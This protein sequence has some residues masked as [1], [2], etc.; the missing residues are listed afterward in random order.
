MCCSVWTFAVVVSEYIAILSFV[1][2]K[3]F[4][5]LQ[6]WL[7]LFLCAADSDTDSV[8]IIWRFFHTQAL[9]I[10]IWN[11]TM[12]TIKQN[13]SC[14][15]AWWESPIKTPPRLPACT[16]A[17]I[18]YAAQLSCYFHEFLLFAFI[19]RCSVFLFVWILVFHH[20][21]DSMGLFILMINRV[22][23]H[24]VVVIKY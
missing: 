11:S 24:F 10:R 7:L 4:A 22:I 2:F 20:Y 21:W 15:S 17:S 8:V 12:V 13:A 5:A 3:G 16:V 23:G 1:L 6:S 9:R 18:N 14:C 19:L